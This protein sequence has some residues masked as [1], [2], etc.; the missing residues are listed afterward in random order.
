MLTLLL[1]WLLVGFVVA[2]AFG[3]LVRDDELTREE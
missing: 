1:L 3:Y 2:V